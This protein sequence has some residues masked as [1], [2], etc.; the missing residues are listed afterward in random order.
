MEH[1]YSKKYL[2]LPQQGGTSPP[3]RPAESVPLITPLPLSDRAV[4]GD[5]TKGHQSANNFTDFRLLSQN[6]QLPAL[7][8][9]NKNW[10]TG[11]SSLC[12]VVVCDS[13]RKR[14]H[15]MALVLE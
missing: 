11:I 6:L 9:R 4:G 1:R 2:E 3:M 8:I 13:R 12:P 10:C 5:A 14:D 15:A 7:S